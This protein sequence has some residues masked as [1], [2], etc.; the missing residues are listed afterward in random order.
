MARRRTGVKKTRDI[1][2]YSMTTALSARQIAR[3][4]GISRTVVATTIRTFKAS[5]LEYAA[6]DSMPDSSLMQ[7]LAGDEIPEKSARYQDLSQRFPA[8]VV[9]LKKK[10]VTL[11]WLWELYIQ[12][13]PGGYQYS[14]YCLNFHRWR[15]SPDIVM[16]IEHKAGEEMFVD[17]AGDKLEVING[18]TGQPWA[19]EQF[20][21]ILGASELTYVEARES[22]GEEDWI[23]ANEGALWYWGGS[24][25]A[26]IPDN[27]KTAV[28]RTD[29]YEPGLNPI[30]DDFA[31][32]YGLV[33]VPARIRRAR[34]KA[35]VE[36]AVR[37]V[38][39]RI[40]CRLRG[41][42]F[43][44]LREV[45][46]AIRALLEEHN[47][48]PFSRLPISRRQ[49]FEQVEKQALR[50]L[51]AE[52]FPLKST[53]F[54]TVQCNYHA[55]LRE[56]LHYYSVPHYLRTTEPTTQVKLV[57][58]DRVVALYCDNVRVA[59]HRRDRTPNGYTTLEEHMPPAH[60][61]Y[62]KWSPERFLGWA[63]A[64]GPE[65][66]EVIAKVLDSRTYA[67]QA[68]KVCLGILNLQRPHGTVRLNKACA[69]AL[70]FGTHSYTRIRNI[71]AQGLEEEGQPQLEL[72]VPA[73]PEHE[74]LRG[75]DYYN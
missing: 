70:R 20:V 18:N 14:Q 73:L 7:A 29:P 12:E 28:A 25:T 36:N 43:H 19:L 30:F 2:R 31:R 75:S 57:Y 10:G 6:I 63:R 47:N 44:S 62:A 27:T 37:L 26:V 23:R 42:V 60:R 61:W 71:L 59:Q 74:N 3:A 58:D 41:K 48:R 49:L 38:Y 52:R 32:H 67:P 11:Q 65:T 56:D 53:A 45:N 21:A 17:W 54:A 34:D 16:H 9:E 35:L 40:S 55:Q 13:Y 64:V 24:S 22:Q 15:K 39:Q 33:I 50:P 72:A 4:L 66:E 8:M 51:P 1:I 5:G 68:F 46:E 69:R